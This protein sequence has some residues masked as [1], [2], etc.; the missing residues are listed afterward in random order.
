[1][2]QYLI[3]VNLGIVRS[4]NSHQ[5]NTTMMVNHCQHHD[6]T[7]SET[8]MLQNTI[9][10]MM[11]VMTLIDS[12]M[13]IGFE[14]TEAKSIGK[15]NCSLYTSQSNMFLTPPMSFSEMVCCGNVM[16]HRSPC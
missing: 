13:S 5:D 15:E 12:G 11:F 16:P 3:P 9:N 14:Q 8:I 6:T 7:T 10:G 4:I 1:M 2:L